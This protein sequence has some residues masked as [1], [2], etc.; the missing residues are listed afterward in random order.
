MGCV[1]NSQVINKML[2]WGT[3]KEKENNSCHWLHFSWLI[4]SLFCITTIN[5]HRAFKTY[6][7]WMC[8][9]ASVTRNDTMTD[10]IGISVDIV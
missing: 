6:R 8:V 7:K 4:M 2:S 5:M 10:F 3:K 1:V 9:E